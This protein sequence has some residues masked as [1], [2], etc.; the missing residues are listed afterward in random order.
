MLHIHIHNI[1]TENTAV[2][3]YEYEVFVNRKE[4]DKGKILGHS[5]GDYRDLIIQWAKQL[6]EEKLVEITKTIN[7]LGGL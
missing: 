7:E 3:N 5:R 4:I 1:G 6:E 2:G